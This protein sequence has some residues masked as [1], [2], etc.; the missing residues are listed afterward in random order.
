MRYSCSMRRAKVMVECIIFIN[1]LW[2]ALLWRNAN[3]I[4]R[5]I[6]MICEHWLLTMHGNKYLSCPVQIS[7]GQGII[8]IELAEKMLNAVVRGWYIKSAGVV[9]FWNGIHT[10]NIKDAIWKHLHTI[11]YQIILSDTNLLQWSLQVNVHSTL[12]KMEFHQLN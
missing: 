2:S 4:G 1:F 7:K 8:S 3:T 11:R 9:G 12:K 10:W 5:H 6:H